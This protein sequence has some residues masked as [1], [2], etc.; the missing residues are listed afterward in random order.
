[1]K[2]AVFI[3]I[4]SLLGLQSS[5]NLSPEY[6]CLTG[7]SPCDLLRV[8][9]KEISTIELSLHDKFR[10]KDQYTLSPL[11]SRHQKSAIASLNTSV[12]LLPEALT[13]K[14]SSRSL[15]HHRGKNKKHKALLG[16]RFSA[17]IKVPP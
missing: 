12:I 6:T 2:R 10:S 14:L 15:S 16:D 13:I 7:I 4:L 17:D 5:G 1:M 8:N 9:P 11:K 3:S